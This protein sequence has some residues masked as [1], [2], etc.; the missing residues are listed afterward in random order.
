MKNEWTTVL[1]LV[2]LLLSTAL[3][4]AYAQAPKSVDP[5]QK[6]QGDVAADSDTYIIGPEDVLHIYVWKEES[7]TKTV[8]VRMDGKI[9]LPLVDDI[10]AADLT[11]LQL[12]EVLT[13]K[14]KDYVDN[15]TVTITVMEANSF[16]VYLTG[17]V[18]NPGVVRLRS[19][20]SLVKLIIMVGGFTQWANQKKI[21][22]ITKEKGVE[23]RITA[24]Y[25]KIIDGEEQD[26]I[27]RRGDTVIVK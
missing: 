22:V 2:L 16:K 4:S 5:P 3:P 18:K 20:T 7:L 21:L 11:P 23:K 6:T 15:P 13:K 1:L 26:V 8:P 9:S 27:I 12:K 24:N 17:E 19:E 25:K 14:L 10:Q